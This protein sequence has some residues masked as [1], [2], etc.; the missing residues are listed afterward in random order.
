MTTSPWELADDQRPN[1][2][3]LDGTL[4]VDV[5]IVGGGIAGIST[6][7]QLTQAGKKVALVEM[8]RIG[9][10][11]TGWTTAFVTWVTD[12]SLQHLKDTRG[13]EAA[14]LAWASSRRA[15]QEIERIIQA[16]KIDCEFMTCPTFVFA[17]EAGAIEGLRQE[18]D[19]A[20]GFGFPASLE[21]A[22]LGFATPGY[23]RVEDQ[24]KFHA[25]KYVETLAVRAAAQG[26]LVFENSEVT[27][28]SSDGSGI[29]KTASGEI[30]AA[31]VVIATYLP[32]GNPAQL[33][34]RVSPTLDHVIEAR[35]PKGL[36]SEALYWDTVNP[37]HYFR[38]DRYED[39]D[40]IILGGEGRKAGQPA[41]DSKARF[42]RLQAF[43]TGLLPA[44]T[45][46]EI[47]RQW[48]GETLEP[49]DGLPFIGRVEE[50]KNTYVAT[51]FS[52]TGMTFGT[53]SGLILRDLI[54]GKED[55]TSALY[56]PTRPN[57]PQE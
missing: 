38:I 21:T 44:G 46:I 6:A 33:A 35:I 56:R 42:E 14:A 55:E 8:G 19:L 47:V 9:E 15:R 26:A 13:P 22:S 25:M 5:A 11:A 17:S 49:N 36:L 32:F 51:G 37:Y 4:E 10:G 43:L 2:P 40:R 45:P 50:G 20:K 52:G 53:L 27:S 7:Y 54:L 28:V 57:A 23:L 3:I 16:E 31:H 30:R 39:H 12:A 1:F 34:S 48:R 29:V 41:S 24:G 18:A